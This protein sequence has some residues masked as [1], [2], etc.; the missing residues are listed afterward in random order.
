[1]AASSSLTRI[2]FDQSNRQ[3]PIFFEQVN[4]LDNRLHEICHFIPIRLEVTSFDDETVLEERSLTFHEVDQRVHAKLFHG[5][6]GLRFIEH[7]AKDSALV[8]AVIC[9]AAPAS[10]RRAGLRDYPAVS[11]RGVGAGAT[12]ENPCGGRQEQHLRH[13][14]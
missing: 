1:M 9:A 12:R 7:Q 2:Y 11:H 6:G 4:R 14:L 3:S 8:R 13:Y 5:Y 10:R